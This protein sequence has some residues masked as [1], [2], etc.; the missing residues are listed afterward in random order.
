MKRLLLYVHFNKYDKLSDYVLYQLEKMRPLFSHVVFIS[1][2]QLHADDLARLES[3][4][5]FDDFIQRENRGYDFAAWQAG[6][7]H[8]GFEDMKTYD[9]VTVMNDTCFGPLWDMQPYYEKYEQ[10]ET[11]DFWGMTNHQ[12]T[13]AEVFYIHEHVQSYFMSFKQKLVASSAFTK[14][15]RGVEAYEDVN[16]VIVNYETKFTKHLLDAGF[17][18]ETVLDT[19][20]IVKD[21]P[22]SNFSIHFPYVLMAQKVPFIKV[23]TFDLVRYLSPY[24]LQSIER[25]TDYPVQLIVSHMSDISEPTPSYLLGRKALQPAQQAYSN[26]KK[27]AVHLHTY[28]V[29]L[30]PDFLKEFEHL[31]FDYDLFLTTDTKEKKAEIEAILSA[32]GKAGRVYI[33]GNRGRDVIPMLKLKV[34][35]AEYDYIGHFHTKKSPEY[36]HWVGDSWREE[37]F[38]M[39]LRPAD[40]ILAQLEQNDK[41]GLVIADIASFF[42]Y[43]YIVMP[44]NEKN[45]APGMNDLWQRMKLE[46]QLD[47]SKMNTFIMSYGTFVWFKYDA[48]QPL[49]DLEL[50]E[51]EIAPEPIPLHTIMHSIERIVVYLAWARGYDYAISKNDLYI[52]P[53]VDNR[54][55]NVER[56]QPSHP[57]YVDFDHLGGI[58]GALKYIFRGPKDAI[59]YIF[60]RLKLKRKLRQAERRNKG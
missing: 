37:L 8:V 19:R 15:W 3:A 42:R 43:N 21:F 1:N 51:D 34:L 10:D 45:F 17:H 5:L 23:K 6:M 28:Y 49:F 4:H 39:M 41:L 29:D 60:K 20:P 46:R 9:S 27:V 40:N 35:L 50:S 33:T 55:L 25:E 36:A 56:A 7:L 58:S 2:S 24:T 31:H 47:F 16:D 59:V 54:V 13:D 11:V 44:W 57:T 12:E 14:F 22:H 38:Q 32:E 30:L 48:F 18:Y 52:T 53:F 26:S